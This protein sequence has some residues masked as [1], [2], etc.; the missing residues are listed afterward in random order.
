M[1]LSTTAT[2]TAAI[3]LTTHPTYVLP[4]GER[5]TGQ[6]VITSI[7]FPLLICF[8]LAYMATSALLNV[9]S[10][11]MATLTQCWCVSRALRDFV[12]CAVEQGLSHM[13]AT[14]TSLIPITCT[15]A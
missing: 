13:R 3:L 9:L 12:C 2:A 14:R 4:G 6:A 5:G 11:T 7:G 1:T 8:L 15:G 10:M